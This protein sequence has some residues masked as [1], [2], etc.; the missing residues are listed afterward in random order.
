MLRKRLHYM[1]TPFCELVNDLTNQT[2]Q[3]IILSR[4]SPHM[5]AFNNS[6]FMVLSNLIMK[7][8]INTA[9]YTSHI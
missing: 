6:Y 1:T 3:G 8:Q 4:H 2:T 7:Q 5:I 9:Y